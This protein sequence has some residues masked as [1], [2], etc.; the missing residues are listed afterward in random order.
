MPVLLRIPLDRRIA[1][2]YCRGETLVQ[3]MPQWRRPF[4][5]LFQ[6]IENLVGPRA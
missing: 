2:S 6:S 4:Q 5:G 3:G 1:E